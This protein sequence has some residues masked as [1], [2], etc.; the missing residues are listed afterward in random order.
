MDDLLPRMALTLTLGANRT[1]KRVAD[2]HALPPRISMKVARIRGQVPEID[3]VPGPLTVL[4]IRALR[5]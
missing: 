2:G 4:W 3:R 1:T 5:A